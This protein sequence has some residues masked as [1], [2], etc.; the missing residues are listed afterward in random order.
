MTPARRCASSRLGAG[1]IQLVERTPRPTPGASRFVPRPKAEVARSSAQ[2]RRRLSRVGAL[3]GDS[4]V[5]VVGRGR[6]ACVVR[7]GSGAVVQ[8][9]WY[10]YDVGSTPASLGPVLKNRPSGTF[11]C[12]TKGRWGTSTSRRNA[13]L[14]APAGRAT[15]SGVC[16]TLMFTFVLASSSSGSL[17]GHATPFTGPTSRTIRPESQFK[18]ALRHTSTP[19]TEV[20]ADQAHPRG[21]ATATVVRRG[22]ALAATRC[23]QCRCRLMLPACRARPR[24][25]ATPEA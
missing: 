15:S 8:F 2:G 23:A 3:L 22:E 20:P 10:I 24:S 13:L 14:R 19:N 16:I 17:R 11:G 21:V 4:S 5:D 25:R 6:D 12:S 9:P 18:Q 7:R 1:V